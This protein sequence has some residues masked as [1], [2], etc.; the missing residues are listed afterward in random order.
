MNTML[1]NAVQSVQIGVEDYLSKNSRRAL[2]AVRNVSA[3]ILLLFKE[4]LRDS[5]Q[6]ALTRFSSNKQSTPRLT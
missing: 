1:E 5:R 3:G 4:K 2:S 6:M